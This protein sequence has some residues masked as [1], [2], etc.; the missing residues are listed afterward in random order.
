MEILRQF[1]PEK[2]HDEKQEECETKSLLEAEDLKLDMK[3]SDHI[4]G[5]VV[6]A[7]DRNDFSSDAKVL[8]TK[9]NEI[10][11]FDE[12]SQNHLI[13]NVCKSCIS[14]QTICC[15]YKK[16]KG[17]A[18]SIEDV[19]Q[20]SESVLICCNDS[21]EFCKP[22]VLP[23]KQ[24]CMLGETYCHLVSCLHEC[25]N[26]EILSANC[27][28]DKLCFNTPNEVNIAK[29]VPSLEKCAS[30]EGELSEAKVNHCAASIPLLC[31]ELDSNKNSKMSVIEGSFPN[32]GSDACKSTN[33][34]DKIRTGKIENFINKE[35]S[36]KNDEVR[37]MPLLPSK[38]RA[39]LYSRNRSSRFSRR[40]YQKEDG[41]GPVRGGRND[42]T[43][44]QHRNMQQ[45]DLDALCGIVFVEQRF[46]AKILYHLLNVSSQV[47]GSVTMLSW[48]LHG[49]SF[50]SV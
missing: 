22:K 34:C 30:C 18:S 10:V 50:C 11:G 5:N 46:T 19:I 4:S 20:E 35:I 43:G 14:E 49:Y 33:D 44:R 24:E 47:H 31:K 16:G 2:L 28:P 1:K 38:N 27:V 26:I 17:V 7:E 36:V 48:F 40:S 8:S 42:T 45:D 3:S 23:E 37:S 39:D 9:E 6:V 15:S 29:A 32:H 41:G 25:N 13:L 12:G 21:K